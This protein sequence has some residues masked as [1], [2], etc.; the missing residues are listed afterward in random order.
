MQECS[1]QSRSEG[2]VTIRAP[3]RRVA[4]YLVVG[5]IPFT[6]NLGT[7][8]LLSLAGISVGFATSLA[9]LVGGQVAFWSHDRISF[10]DRYTELL[11]WPR[12]WRRFMPGQLAG[13][14]L[15]WSTA[16]LLAE[17][18]ELSG[19]IIWALA[20]VAGITATFSWTNWFSHHGKDTGALPRE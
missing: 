7:F 5:L 3:S 8:Q 15:N 6:A 20:T 1:T 17:F 11:G 2:L 14:G 19:I 13:F 4:L 9:F 16:N 10:G 18:S 12:R